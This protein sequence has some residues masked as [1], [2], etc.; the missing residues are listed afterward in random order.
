MWPIPWLTLLLIAFF[1]LIVVEFFILYLRYSAGFTLFEVILLLLFPLFLYVSSVPYWVAT[2]HYSILG[3]VTAP[4]LYDI[5]LFQIGNSI[6]GVNVVG[7]FIPVIVSSKIVLEKRVPIKESIVLVG[8]IS[9]VTYLYTSFRPEVG[10]VIYFFAVPSLLSAG[11]SFMFRLMNPAANPALLSYV[12][13]T[14][15]VLIGAD[16]LNI[17]KAV[18]YPWRNQVFISIGGGGVLDAIFLAGLVSIFADVLIRSQS[19]DIIG[20]FI[21]IFRKL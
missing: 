17:C 12:G 3:L 6:V 2:R 11:V 14:L 21:D 4:R 16:I 5:P 9:F 20:S 19:E 7:F 15:G 13:A 1:V 18:Y 10:I 8:I